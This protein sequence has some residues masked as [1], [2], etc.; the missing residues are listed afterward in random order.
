ML[1]VQT[2][3]DVQGAPRMMN[4]ILG[5]IL[6]S[7]G[8]GDD[9]VANV[10]TTMDD[11]KNNCAAGAISTSLDRLSGVFALI[12]T[13]VAIPT[14]PAGEEFGDVHDMDYNATDSK[15]QDPV[16]WQHA[17]YPANAGLQTQVG[18]LIQLR[19]M[20]PALQRNDVQF[21][22]FYPTFDAND[23]AWVIAYSRTNGVPLG[24]SGQVIV[25]ANMCVP[26]QP[27]PFLGKSN[28]WRIV[29]ADN[30]VLLRI[31]ISCLEAS[32][33]DRAVGWCL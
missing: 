33:K 8:L 22:Y 21:F 19:T 2:S 32:G 12:M 11:T 14:F 28:L 15:Q 20:H 7:L 4:V 17:S 27:A 29:V 5:P 23:G 31:R 1:G 3:H 6:Q 13:S 24:S 25:I 18:Q 26:L 10:K 9:G 30:P 16:Q